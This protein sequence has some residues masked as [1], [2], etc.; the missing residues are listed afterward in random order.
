[1]VMHWATQ[2]RDLRERGLRVPHIAEIIGTTPAKVEAAIADM[3]IAEAPPAARRDVSY[4]PAPLP[5]VFSPSTAL[6]RV[7]RRTRWLHA[8]CAHHGVTWDEVIGTWR[9]HHLVAVRWACAVFLRDDW[10][11][12][13]SQIGKLMR[14]DHS[15][16][17]Y[18]VR[19]GRRS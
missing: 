1:M 5:S 14:R 10:G 2:A 12:S 7:E 13:Y 8:I 19:R 18:S 11:M 17:I 16:I 9:A 4:A 15:T 6:T 3:E